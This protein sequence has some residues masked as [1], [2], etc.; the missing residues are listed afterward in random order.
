MDDLQG[1]KNLVP[2][3]ELVDDVVHELQ[4]LLDEVAHRNLSLA[5]EVDQLAVDAVAHCPPLV[6]GDQVRHVPP[7]AEVVPPQLQHL[8]T[9]RLRQRRQANGFVDTC[10][11]VADPKLQGRVQMVRSQ[12]PPDLL[13]VVD[14]V[15]LHEQL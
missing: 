13:A 5:T 12:I 11:R 14:A 9:Y 2:A 3:F 6:L 1:V 15:R 10:G 8:R 7:E 4:Q